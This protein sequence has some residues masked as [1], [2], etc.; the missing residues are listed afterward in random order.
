MNLQ[1]DLRIIFLRPKNSTVEAGTVQWRSGIS[2]RWGRQLSRRGAPTY[3]FAKFSQKLHEIERIWT[4]TG[5]RASKILLCTSATTVPHV[6]SW[7]QVRPMLVHMYKYVDHK[8]SAAMLAIKR[9]SEVNLEVN[10]HQLCTLHWRA[11]W[12]SVSFE[13]ES[14]VMSQTWGS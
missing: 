5:A 3:H 7:V 9:S 12:L 10:S 13:G 8:G 1:R 6:L 4:P 11:K 2:P 14:S